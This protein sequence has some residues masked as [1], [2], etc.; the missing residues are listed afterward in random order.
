M[1]VRS[2]QQDI[3]LHGALYQMETGLNRVEYLQAVLCLASTYSLEEQSKFILSLYQHIGK[4]ENDEGVA[5][6]PTLQP[7][8]KS[9]PAV[10]YIHFA[11]TKASVLLDVMKLQNVKKPVELWWSNDEC[12]MSLIHCLPY[13]SQLRQVMFCYLSD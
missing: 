3:L 4:Y 8:F 5:V 6:L 7:V 1:E 10:W 9:F 12:D 2:F 13:I 11:D